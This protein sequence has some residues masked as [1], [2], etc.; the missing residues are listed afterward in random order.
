[1][2]G[3]SLVGGFRYSFISLRKVST[4]TQMN[5]C[6][7]C[8]QASHSYA[9]VLTLAVYTRK[10]KK[11]ISQFSKMSQEKRGSIFWFFFTFPHFWCCPGTISE[12][13]KVCVLFLS[14]FSSPNVNVWLWLKHS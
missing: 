14:L 4:E 1:L 10:N 9:Q 11:G 8:S 6:R 5:F 12:R 2:H 7:D 13:A 3:D